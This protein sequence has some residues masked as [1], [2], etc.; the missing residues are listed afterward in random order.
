MEKACCGLRRSSDRDI[1]YAGGCTRA[2]NSL[3]RLWT[4]PLAF[5]NVGKAW[6]VAI[7]AVVGGR[8]EYCNV[9]PRDVQRQ[10]CS[11]FR[12]V[13]I[14]TAERVVLVE[15]V[16]DRSNFA[17]QLVHPVPSIREKVSLVPPC[18]DQAEEAHDRPST[19]RSRQTSAFFS[20]SLINYFSKS[21]L[22]ECLQ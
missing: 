7:V 11:W 17:M 4:I 9:N 1:L 22:N 21:C 10:C 3:R 19:V 18:P 13:Y 16:A 8:S 2:V 6:R 14:E 12:D 20:S 5:A 15:R